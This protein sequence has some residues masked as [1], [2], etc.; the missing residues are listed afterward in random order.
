[1]PRVLETINMME[2]IEVF[3]EELIEDRNLGR[4]G[5]LNEEL[6]LQETLVI[7]ILRKFKR[8]CMCIIMRE[9]V[10]MNF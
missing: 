4:G 3:L 2:Y 10:L 7:S 9:I 1:M 5:G 8:N 6:F